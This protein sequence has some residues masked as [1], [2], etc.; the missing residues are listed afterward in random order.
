VRY[1]V[2]VVGIRWWRDAK[3]QLGAARDPD[4]STTNLAVYLLTSHCNTPHMISFH[5]YTILIM[6]LL[7]HTLGIF[8]KMLLFDSWCVL[9]HALSEKALF[10]KQRFIRISPHRGGKWR[11]KFRPVYTMFQQQERLAST[12]NS[13]FAHRGRK[14]AQVCDS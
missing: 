1:V 12:W 10:S 8:G 6:Y 7:Y 3:L 14:E 4:L 9:I 11:N 5:S 13:H 2:E